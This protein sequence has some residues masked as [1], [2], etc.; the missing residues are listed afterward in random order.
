[1]TFR[2]RGYLLGAA[3]LVVTAWIGLQFWLAHRAFASMNATAHARTAAWYVA[4]PGMH[5]T[6]NYV[7]SS[8]W[9][10]A[11]RESAFELLMVVVV[12]VALAVGG[13]RWWTLL[14]AAFPAAVAGGHFEDGTSIGQGWIQPTN[15]A[16]SWLGVGV[17]VDTITLL[18]VAALLVLALPA[19]R[20]RAAAT[21]VASSTS[22]LF[23]AAPA[24][25]VL[26]GWWL[27]RHPIADP[28][29][30]VWLA[31][32]VVWMVVVALIAS[33]SPPLPV[34]AVTVLGL[35][36]MFSF[37]IFDDLVVGYAHV[38]DGTRYLHHLAVA[39]A[40]AAYVIAVPALTRAVSSHRAPAPATA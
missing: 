8:Y 14:V 5:L 37:T 24:A 20:T 17:A 23:R 32:A 27:V 1:V 35:L 21:W 11:G 15:A 13:R 39:A 29:D 34:R 9:P 6:V 36:P 12:A 33:S 19:W 38:F 18:V 7:P 26:I 4:H 28:D 31:Q 2:S 16:Q 25:V 22:T 3:A 30:R 40:I 10:D